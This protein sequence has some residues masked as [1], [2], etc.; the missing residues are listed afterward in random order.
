M[1]KRQVLEF[2]VCP[3]RF[4]WSHHEPGA[5]EL[6]PDEVDQ[7]RFAEGQA[8]GRAAREFLPGREYER[9]FDADDH[10]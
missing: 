1:N 4:W 2:M 3:R 5:P 10:G 7:D 8:V 9:G 6:R